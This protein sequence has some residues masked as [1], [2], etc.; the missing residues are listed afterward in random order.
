MKP[1]ERSLS[2][3][4][5]MYRIPTPPPRNNVLELCYGG[6]SIV[7]EPS[8]PGT[9]AVIGALRGRFPAGVTTWEH[10]HPLRVIEHGTE[11]PFADRS[12]DLVI[13]H[14]TLDR[15]MQAEASFRRR[16]SLIAFL[17]RVRRVLA[18]GGIVAGCVANRTALSR[19]RS[20]AAEC[21]RGMLSIHSCRKLLARSGFVEIE[22]FNVLPSADSPLRLINTVA[23][24]SRQGFRRELEVVHQSLSPFGYLTRRVSVELALNRFFEES[25]LFWGRAR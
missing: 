9:F 15:L 4:C 8:W 20:N 1:Y 11:L 21:R 23:D 16:G 25:I 12:F 6:P 13:L 14:G 10:E 2:R 22:T 7:T 5:A 19:W 17:G 18:A 3:V 24:L